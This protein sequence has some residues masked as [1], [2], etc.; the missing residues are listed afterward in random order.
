MSLYPKFLKKKYPLPLNTLDSQFMCI[1][2]Y[3]ACAEG[4]IPP[5]Q[6]HLGPTAVPRPRMMHRKHPTL[7]SPIPVIG[8]D[9]THGGQT[10]ADY[11]DH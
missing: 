2:R 7:C 3:Q 4:G 10:V 6:G 1:G 8:I 11:D 5:S 9:R